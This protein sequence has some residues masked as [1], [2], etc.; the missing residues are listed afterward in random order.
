MA[1]LE[2]STIEIAPESSG[3]QTTPNAA[4]DAADPSTLAERL[5]GL[6]G[7]DTNALKTEW[8]RLYRSLPP[9]G[10]SRDLLIRA[11][12]FK[13]QEHLHGGLSRAVKRRLESFAADIDSGGR[14]RAPAISLRAGAR[15]IREWQGKSHQV[16][17]LEEGFEYQG[18]RYQSLSKIAS[19]ITGTHWSGPRFFGIKRRPKPFVLKGGGDE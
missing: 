2:H 1:M 4:C 19:D 6:E 12:A 15:L 9:L 10:L 16:L 17:V 5:T 14:E 7:L 11:I 13:L 18:K 3:Y 8:R